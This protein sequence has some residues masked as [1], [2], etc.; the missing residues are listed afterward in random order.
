MFLPTL[1]TYKPLGWP[2]PF[3]GSELGIHSFIQQGCM[4][5]YWV[6][7][8]FLGSGAMPVNKQTTCLLLRH[9]HLN[10]GG[11]AIKKQVHSSV[12]FSC[13]V[14]SDSL[15]PRELQ[16]A[17]PPCPSP[18]PGVHPN[19]CPLSQWCHPAISSS[20]VPFP[21]CPQFPTNLDSILK[22]RDITLS[23]K[24]HLVK[25][26]VF[27]CMDVRVGLWRKLSA[28]ELMLLNCGVGED[29]WESLGLQGDPTSPF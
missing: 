6:V 21:S 5:T 11:R 16:H 10:E 26:M 19:P 1:Y 29:S 25:V 23:T 27:P 28:E 12:Q 15:Q 2:I 22:S 9:L 17:R 20:V 3:L 4:S 7:S 18:T 14:V 13:S 24:V 8:T